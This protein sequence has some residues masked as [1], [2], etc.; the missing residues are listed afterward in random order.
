LSSVPIALVANALRV[1]A[2]GLLAFNFGIGAAEGFLHSFTGAFVFVFAFA[3][4]LIEMLLLQRL[5]PS[6]NGAA[7]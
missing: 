7:R 3:A 4:L 1:T 6:G 5:A 2:T